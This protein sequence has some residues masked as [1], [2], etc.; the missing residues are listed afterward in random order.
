MKKVLLMCLA[1]AAMTVSCSNEEPVSTNSV[2]PQKSN[3]ID[4]RITPNIGDV[5]DVDVVHQN[6]PPTNIYGTIKLTIICKQ[7]TY[8]GVAGDDW[9]GVGM[10]TAGNYY[11]VHSSVDTTIGINGKPSYVRH[12]TGYKYTG[13]GKPAIYGC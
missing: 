2:I 12:T 7:I 9:S 6:E 5:I 4:I 10:D 1:I 3:P 11:I 13:S 8:H